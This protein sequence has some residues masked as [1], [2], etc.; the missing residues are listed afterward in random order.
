MPL[1]K[2]NGKACERRKGGRERAEPSNPERTK[3]SFRCMVSIDR[4]THPHSFIRQAGCHASIGFPGRCHLLL[5]T[6]HQAKRVCPFS[7]R[8]SRSVS[9]KIPYSYGAWEEGVPQQPGGRS[10]SDKCLTAE[11]RERRGCPNSRVADHSVLNA[12]QLMFVG[13]AP[14]AEW[15]I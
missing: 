2:N 15:P 3:G 8:Y 5:H 7:W 14:T 6:I 9:A 10:L 13:C 4:S 11:G 1:L 12:S